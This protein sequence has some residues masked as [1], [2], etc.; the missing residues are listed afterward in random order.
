MAVAQ[1][2]NGGAPMYVGDSK[3]ELIDFMNKQL[4]VD[5]DLTKIKSVG[6]GKWMYIAIKAKKKK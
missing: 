5:V 2:W 3:Q 1:K 4:N 6:D